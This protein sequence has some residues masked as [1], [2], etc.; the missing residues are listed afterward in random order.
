M[1]EDHHNLSYT[2]MRRF[3]VKSGRLSIRH[4]GDDG[5]GHEVL[6]EF[7]PGVMVRILDLY[8]VQ[9]GESVL[10]MPGD[11]LMLVGKL[12]GDSEIR[13]SDGQSAQLNVGS[14]LIAY[15]NQDLEVIESA[16]FESHYLL[17]MLVCDPQML[18][19][20]PFNMDIE[21]LPECF[22]L[23]LDQTG[24]INE[25]Y[26]MSSDL[27]QS[28]RGLLSGLDQSLLSNQFL[29]AKTIELVCLAVRNIL[30]EQAQ[31]ERSHI[32]D[33]EVRIISKASQV[34]QDCWQSP[35]SLDELVKCLGMGKSR[36]TS[37]FK[38]IHGCTI[39]NYLL[40]VRM[41]K[42]QKLLSEGR[43]NVT[44]VALEVGYEHSSNFAS[45][46]KRH[47]GMTPKVFKKMPCN[48]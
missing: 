38:S 13:I 25:S 44:Q 19:H 12:A 6:F 34:L 26:S 15:H 21:Q 16:D 18:I 20:P 7:Q 42:A 9:A 4:D 10:K 46:F 43:L 39:G 45:A 35:P 37:C 40:N 14:L 31:R 1:R 28:M 27:M 48:K 33:K 32:S 3:D 24:F 22:R 29:Q 47:T 41:Q 8:D 36:L 30:E 2:D 11:K 17:V 5:V 23:A